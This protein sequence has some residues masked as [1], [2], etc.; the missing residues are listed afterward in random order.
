MG[1]L[2]LSLCAL[3]WGRI[4]KTAGFDRCEGILSGLFEP[5]WENVALGSS[6]PLHNRLKFV[7]Q[8]PDP[9]YDSGLYGL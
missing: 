8:K 9:K 5:A 2:D 4:G 6:G 7:S 1:F 3:S